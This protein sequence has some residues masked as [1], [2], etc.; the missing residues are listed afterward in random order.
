MEAKFSVCRK[1]VSQRKFFSWTKMCRNF[2]KM[3][4]IFCLHFMRDAATV[5]E[6]MAS[7]VLIASDVLGINDYK[8]QCRWI[9]LQSMMGK[10][11]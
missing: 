11:G 8:E 7:G 5:L 9:T 4:D 3:F 2:L 6:A 10:A 1:V